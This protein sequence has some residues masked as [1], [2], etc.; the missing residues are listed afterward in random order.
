MGETM[1]KETKIV[2]LL[3]MLLSKRFLALAFMFLY[4]FSPVSSIA[5]TKIEQNKTIEIRVFQDHWGFK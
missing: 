4:F 1:I 3:N 2:E 5:Q